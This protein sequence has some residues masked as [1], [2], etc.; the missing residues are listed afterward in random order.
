MQKDCFNNFDIYFLKYIF[1][2]FYAEVI[3][4][5]KGKELIITGKKNFDLLMTF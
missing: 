4:S 1:S 3:F 5:Y 2:F